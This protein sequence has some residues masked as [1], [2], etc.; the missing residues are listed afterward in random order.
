MALAIPVGE[1][2]KRRR[3]IRS[4]VGWTMKPEALHAIAAVGESE[5]VEFKKST[6]QFA[7]AGETLCAFLNANGGRVFIGIRAGRTHSRPACEGVHTLPFGLTPED[8]RTVHASRPRNPNIT[9]VFYRR[10]LLERWGRGTNRVIESTVALGKPETVNAQI[11]RC[12]VVTFRFARSLTAQVTG[13]VTGEVEHLLE[14]LSTGSLGRVEIQ[15]T[16][17]LHSQ[18]N[19]RDR[20]LLPALEADV[21]ERTI[22]DKPNS[23]LQKYRL[24][25]KGQ[26]LLE[27]E[28][29]N[30]R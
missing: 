24:A 16:L 3:N 5:T 30:F 28:G 11:A 27:E 4:S 12:T 8:L 10:G 15:S 2:E 6:A 23:R 26:V 17:R 21:I 29:G 13:K 25:E 22:P 18:A 7:R 20:Y 19:F 9:N 1:R 14:V